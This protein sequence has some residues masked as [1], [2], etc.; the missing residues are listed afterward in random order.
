[1]D[2]D[3]DFDADIQRALELSRQHAQP[4]PPLPVPEVLDEPVVKVVSG[5]KCKFRVYAAAAVGRADLD[6]TGRILL[7][8]SCLTAI[9]SHL[10]E[11]PATLLLRL[12]G[13]E[14]AQSTCYVGVA[15]F[16][17]DEETA[18]MLAKVAGPLIREQQL[19]RVVER[20]GPVAV[21]FV[22]RWVRGALLLDPMAPECSLQVIS[23][24]KA[25]YLQ[26]RPHTDEFAAELAA[27]GSDVRATLTELI[28]RFP[29]ISRGRAISLDLGGHG[30]HNGR[31]QLDVIAVRG[32]P[33]TRCGV[34]ADAASASGGSGGG[35]DALSDAP[36]RVEKGVSLIREE[37]IHEKG[38][39]LIR[40]V[41]IHENGVSVE[42]A[43]LVDADVE[44]EFAPS[45][46]AEAAKEAEARQREAAAAR[47][48][49]A[50]AAAAAAT[51]AEAHAAQA[52]AS[53]AAS[54]ALNRRQASTAALSTVEL[55]SDAAGG[56]AAQPPQLAGAPPPKWIDCVARLPD[57]SRCT[58]RL[59]STAPLLAL[60]WLVDARATE[61]AVPAG[62]EF[63]LTTSY[64][65]RR[66]VRPADESATLQSEGLGDA[67]Q[68]AF[69]VELQS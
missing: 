51:A 62:R 1:M 59:P 40:V 57:G 66:F 68:Q 6:A 56:A 12:V 60:F 50:R 53:R 36:L 3:D 16:I 49:A 46:V 47:A 10:G 55:A 8:H 13:S 18:S 28:N 27:A 19:P 69:F 63:A 21:A 15:E 31:H 17:P 41:V 45:V 14:G 65:R 35:G 4:P 7:P 42:A 5:F 26:L 44:I 2:D 64:P 52:A 43:C 20:V 30:R 29:A 22:P 24:P 11:L 25:C 9:A 32:L 23:L 34:P 58:A 39:S 54:V 61:A 33:G 38:V 37:V 67:P 48:E